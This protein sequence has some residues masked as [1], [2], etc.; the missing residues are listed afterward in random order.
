M[1]AL[2]QAWS[3][4]GEHHGAS[5]TLIARGLPA[6]EIALEAADVDMYLAQPGA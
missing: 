3:A 5:I 2:G 1:L 6:A 4:H